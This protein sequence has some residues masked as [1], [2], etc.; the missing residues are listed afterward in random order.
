MKRIG[1]VLVM[2][3]VAV[4]CSKEKPPEEEPNPRPGFSDDG[5]AAQQRIGQYLNNAVVDSA[6]R[7]CWAQLKGE[8]VV[9]ADLT[10]QKSGDNWAFNTLTVKKSSLTDDQNPIAQRCLEEAVRATSFAVDAKEQLETRATQ[11]I[12]RMGWLVPM[13]PAGTEVSDSAV[14]RMIGTGGVITISGCSTCELRGEP[15]YGYKCVSKSSGSEQDCEEVSTNV[16]AVTPKACMRGTF[17]GTRGLI[18]F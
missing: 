15:P 5:A 18:M 7:T 4:A 9:A 11:F 13:P 16:C 8:G 14:A 6:L 1:I 17:G 3:L 10:Y 2:S 12:V